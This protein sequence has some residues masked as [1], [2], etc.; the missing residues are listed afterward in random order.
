MNK[1]YIIGIGPGHTDY[2]LPVARQYIDKCHVLIGGERNLKTFP[3]FK[4]KTLTINKDLVSLVEFMKRE[5]VDKQIGLILS[6]DT[7]FY[8]MLTFMKKHFKEEEIEVIPGLSSFQYLFAK[9]KETWHQTALMSVHG[10]KQDYLLA[11]KSY[12]SVALLTDQQHSPKEIAKELIENGYETVKITVGE[13]LSYD[14]ERITVGTPMEIMAA[15][16][17]QMSVVIINNE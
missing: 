16:P 8:S 1:I 4:G 9:M 6:G 15:S 11:L 13:N 14:D 3:L 2:V 17:Y 12:S 7:G 5:R 10:R